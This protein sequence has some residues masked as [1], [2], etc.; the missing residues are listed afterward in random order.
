MHEPP[1]CNFYQLNQFIDKHCCTFLASGLHT[2]DPKEQ[3][4]PE[5]PPDHSTVNATKVANEHQ[6]FINQL[7]V[8]TLAMV[9][10]IVTAWFAELTFS[11]GSQAA[12][13]LQSHAKLSF[14]STVTV[15]RV[16]LGWQCHRVSRRLRGY[17]KAAGREFHYLRFWDS[18]RRL[19]PSEQSSKLPGERSVYP[20]G[21]QQHQSEV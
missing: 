13:I 18:H 17:W 19:I 2:M 8:A 10:F 11:M 5:K 4:L 14:S 1:H 7:S 3:P 16:L 6:Y 9:L 15:L 20:T 21:R 12:Y